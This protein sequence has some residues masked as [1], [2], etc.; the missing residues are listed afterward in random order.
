MGMMLMAALLALAVQAVAVMAESGA[1]V[2]QEEL[3]TLLPLALHKE[4]TAATAP[5]P[6]FKLVAV[7]VLTQQEQMERQTAA[8]V[9]VAP[10]LLL[11]AHQ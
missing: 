3:V 8:Q 6:I 2:G 11:Q 4:T 9:A 10:H 5:F 7:V 1:R